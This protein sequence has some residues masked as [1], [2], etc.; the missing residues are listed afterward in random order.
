[1]SITRLFTALP[2]NGPKRL[3]HSE[4]NVMNGSPHGKFLSLQ[5]CHFLLS[6]FLT[7]VSY[8][9]CQFHIHCLSTELPTNV[10]QKLPRC[11]RNG[12]DGSPQGKI[13]SLQVYYFL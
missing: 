6:F 13:L 10:T 9:V 4:S 11:E 3:P 2:T 1:M 7:G 8:F 12:G 5:V